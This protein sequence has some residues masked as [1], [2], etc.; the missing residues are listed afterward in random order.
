MSRIADCEQADEFFVHSRVRIVPVIVKF[1]FH[2][3]HMQQVLKVICEERVAK[4][5]L[6][7]MIVRF[8]I[9]PRPASRR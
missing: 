9:D 8:K 3:H 2:L 5:P 6:I 4:A 7:P 1:Q